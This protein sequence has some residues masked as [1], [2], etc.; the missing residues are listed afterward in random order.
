MGDRE[1]NLHNALDLLGRKVRVEQVSSIY[2]TEPAGYADQPWFLNLVCIGET[3][4]NPD[5]LL[6]FVKEIESQLGRKESFRNAPRLI[7]I[8]IL[9]Y[10]NLVVESDDLTIPHPR[11]SERGFVLVPLE[12]IAS[13]VVHPVKNKTIKSLLSELGNSEQVRKWGNVSD[14]GSAAL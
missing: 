6:T 7:D 5:G 12:E 8:D 3:V 1:A 11:I 2:E 13:L 9:L 4:L 14:I 10:G